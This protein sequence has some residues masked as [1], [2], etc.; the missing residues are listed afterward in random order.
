[1]YRQI[2]FTSVL[3]WSMDVYG[4]GHETYSGGVYIDFSLPSSPAIVLSTIVKPCLLDIS[5]LVISGVQDK[6]SN[7]IVTSEKTNQM[8]HAVFNQQMQRLNQN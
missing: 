7:V 3:S 1:M 6:Y 8:S 4:S 2:C 5:L